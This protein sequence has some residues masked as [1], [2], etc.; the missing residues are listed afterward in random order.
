MDDLYYA[1]N[2][3]WENK[4]F[5]SGIPRQEY[6]GVAERLIGRKQ[7]DVIVG[8]RRVGKTTFIKQLIERCLGSNISAKA[9]LYLALDNP[10]FRKVALSQHLKFFRKIFMHSRTKKLYLFFDEVQES[11]DWEAELKAI[12]DLESVKIVCSGSTSSLIQRQRG[13]LTGRQLITT[14]YPLS[15]NEY[16]AFRKNVPSLS[17]DYKYEKLFEEYLECGG[18][19]EYVLNPSLEYLNNLLEDII[20][21][22]V[23]KLYNIKRAD[24]L[25]D[26]LM[27]LAGSLG[28]RTSYHRLSK[29][30]GIAV[31]T[32][33]EYVGY[34][35][36]AFLVKPLG[37]WSTSYKDRI[38]AQK[39]FYLYDTGIKS[40]LT[41]RGDL[42]VKMENAVF[43]S[44]LKQT[45]PCGYYA[46]SEKEVDFVY[47]SF[48][49]PRVIE[50]KYETVFNWGDK[51]YSG[52]RLFLRRYPGTKDIIVVSKAAEAEFQENK[53]KISVIPAWR[54]LK[55]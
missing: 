3:W 22:D 37:K 2:P 16:L 19:P 51:R 7:I 45:Q 12:Y 52:L 4:G 18:Y 50:A 43:L 17:E 33:K 26:L 23:V 27:L 1:Y 40:L 32:A 28:S 14:I 13:R 9:I 8:S 38:Y 46:E 54:F 36:S 34:L 11:P 44:L 42:G 31:D 15:F 49:L 48:K 6:A 25:K 5:D 39:K 21:R 47:G 29:A 35:E 24:L 41:G 55:K 20:A 53:A 10:R 30:L